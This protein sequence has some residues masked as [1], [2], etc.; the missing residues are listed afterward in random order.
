MRSLD[1][2]TK[3]RAFKNSKN[4]TSDDIKFFDNF[5]DKIQHSLA[6]EK[7]FSKNSAEPSFQQ[8]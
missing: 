8:D 2:K 3:R 5:T 6:I 7:K 1:S 4:L